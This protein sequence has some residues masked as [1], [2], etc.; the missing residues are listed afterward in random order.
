[1]TAGIEN[2]VS[3]LKALHELGLLTSPSDERFERVTRLAKAIFDMPIVLISFID[4]DVQFFK[5]S[6]GIDLTQTPKN[7]SF[8]MH[9]IKEDKLM[10]V[11]DALEDERFKTNQLVLGKPHIR[12]Y[13]GAVLRSYEQYAIGTLC[14]IDTKPRT[15]TEQQKTLLLDLAQGAQNELH[16]HYMNILQQ[17]NER[18]AWICEQSAYGILYTDSD[19]RIVWCNTGFSRLSGYRLEELK[20]KTPGTVLQGADTSSQTIRRLNRQISR[21]KPFEADIL[22]YHKSGQS[23]WVNIQGRP[24]QNKSGQIYGY[25]AIQR[26]VTSRVNRYNELEKLAYVDELTGLT[27]RRYLEEQF[28][29]LIASPLQRGQVAL[30]VIDLDGFKMVNDTYGHQAG[31]EVLREVASR[32]LSLSR[33]GDLI[34]RLGGDEFVMVISDVSASEIKQIGGRLAQL[35]L[36]PIALESGEDVT[37]GMSIGVSCFPDDGS[38]LKTLHS[39]ADQAM[40]Y[41][42]SHKVQLAM[43]SEIET[44]PTNLMNTASGIESSSAT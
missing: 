36:E 34:T 8:C 35:C 16:L 42:K 43:Y 7:I 4:K 13:A 23:Y 28:E 3:R 18:L 29:L 12:F 40:Y 38:S 1:M 31:D 33:Q 15:L 26:D 2:E 10:V 11:E 25:I 39:Q 41:A 5:S 30:F 17:E 20:G 9:A 37:V 6:V 22:N 14:I 19:K 24:L 44:L 21:G 32:L 27:N